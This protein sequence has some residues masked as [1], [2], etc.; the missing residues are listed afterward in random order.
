MLDYIRYCVPDDATHNATYFLLD[1]SKF[2]VCGV[3]ARSPEYLNSLW[4]PE[5]GASVF[6]KVFACTP[7]FTWPPDPYK[8]V[9]LTPFE[10]TPTFFLLM[11]PGSYLSIH[12]FI[13]LWLLGTSAVP[14]LFIVGFR[15]YWCKANMASTAAWLAITTC[16]YHVWANIRLGQTSLLMTALVGLFFLSLC[17]KKHFA[18]AVILNVIAIFKPQEVPIL[19]VMSLCTR[20]YRALFIAA[21]IGAVVLVGTAQALGIQAIINYPKQLADIQ[22]G[23]A[24]GKYFYMM[25]GMANVLSLLIICFGRVL[26][27]QLRYPI[28]LLGLIVC[29]SIWHRAYKAGEHTYKFALAASLPIALITSAYANDYDLTIFLVG[30]ALTVP[31]LSPE[32]I[33]ALKNPYSRIWCYLFLLYPLVETLTGITTKLGGP[34]SLIMSTITAISGYLLFQSKLIEAAEQ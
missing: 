33:N 10:Y 4:I 30:W 8:T 2:Y 34:Y 27:F 29:W 18:M 26:A 22:T 12:R 1:V 13:S 6:A 14:M 5:V 21:A 15:K 20:R 23:I 9:I 16:S 19:L 24:S 31:V 17:K 3:L 25:T 32:R 7:T 11:I 28:M